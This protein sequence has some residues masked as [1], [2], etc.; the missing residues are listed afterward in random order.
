MKKAPVTTNIRAAWRRLKG[1]GCTGAPDLW[2]SACCRDHDA[3]YTFGTDANGTPTTRKA[4]DLAL[5]RC[6][7]AALTNRPAILRPLPWLF[8]FAVRLF[9]RFYWKAPRSNPVKS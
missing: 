1:D 9:G 5:L 4:A 3:A 7:Q 6:T 2:F 8:Y